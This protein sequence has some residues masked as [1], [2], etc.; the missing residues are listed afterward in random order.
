MNP[1]F[2]RFSQRPGNRGLNKDD[3]LRRFLIEERE[4]E[5]LEMWMRL[6]EARQA[7]SS[8]VSS[9]GSGISTGPTPP[10]FGVNEFI[11]TWK[12]DNAGSSTS[13]QI[14]LPLGVYAPSTGY[15]YWFQVDWGDGSTDIIQS[16]TDPKRTHTYSVAGTYTVKISGILDGW[17]F[18]NGGDRLKLLTIEQWG[19]MNVATYAQFAGCANLQVNAPDLPTLIYMGGT[20]WNCTALTNVS[21][22]SEWDVTGVT[23]MFQAFRGCS[24]FNDD[25]TGWDVSNLTSAFRLFMSCSKF[26]RNLGSWN[27]SKVQYLNSMFNAATIFTNGGSPSINNWDTSSVIGIEEMFRSASAFNQPIGNW[28]MSKVTTMRSVF[29]DSP[30]NQPI[31]TWNTGSVTTMADLFLNSP[32]NQDLSNWDFSKVTNMLRFGYSFSTANYNGMLLNWA[33]SPTLQ[34]SV[35]FQTNARYTTT[36]T[37]NKAD[38]PAA[39]RAYVISTYAWSISDGGL[40]P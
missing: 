14:Q 22:I 33:A 2:D 34:R 20:F 12:T 4:R 19:M 6:S 27:M 15:N 7:E 38:D 35:P 29:R 8:A 18:N 26:N 28:D 17:S 32:F 1:K 40:Q 30:F 5:E 31:G 9:G 16:A 25:V 24:N 3:L 37:G 23:D 21:R 13:T 10:P 36:G 11:T 39:A